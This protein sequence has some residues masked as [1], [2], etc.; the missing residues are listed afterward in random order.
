MKRLSVDTPLGPVVLGERN[1]AIVSL[2]WGGDRHGDTTPALTAA[3]TWLNRYFDGASDSPDL[4]LDP[5][6]TAHQ[7]AVWRAM[8]AIPRGT[9]QTYGEVAAAIGSSP[10]AVGGACGANPIPII[11][12]CHRITAGGG[13]IGGYSGAG[14]TV[15]KRF[16]LRLEGAAAL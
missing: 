4:P 11:V 6:G 15:T 8:L 5:G 9:V 16:L 3:R 13:G 2:D 1:G 12:P 14:G 7:C 10:R